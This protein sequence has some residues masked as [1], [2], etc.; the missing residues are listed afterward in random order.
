MARLIGGLKRNNE[1]L[2]IEL[3]VMTIFTIIA[4]RWYKCI[5]SIL[6]LFAKL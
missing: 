1:L 5:S 3:T 6:I 2:V 4:F